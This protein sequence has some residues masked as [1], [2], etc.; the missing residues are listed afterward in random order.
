MFTIP[1]ELHEH[2]V[3][4]PVRA[5]GRDLWFLLD[6]GAG[7][8]L[9]DPA[10]AREAGHPLGPPFHARGAGDGRIEGAMLLSTLPLHPGGFEALRLDARA[11]LP[12]ADLTAAE[13]RRA[14]G[15]LGAD[16][17]TRHVVAIDYAA[18]RLHLHHP[19]EFAYTGPG[20]IVPM[21]LRLNH[22]HVR[23]TVALESGREVPADFV[24]DVG[25][26]LG[27]SLTRRFALEHGFDAAARQGAALRDG[28][29]IGG[30]VTARLTRIASVGIGA[31][32]WH[33]PMV[34]I[35]GEGAGVMSTGEFFD[36]NLGG[37]MLKEFTL[38]LDYARRYVI[39]EPRAAP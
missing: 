31:M 37:E 13:G 16:F 15:I 8:T 1:I 36:A 20:E 34:A 23:G 27:I 2:H 9:V 3:Y 28:R 4:V 25:S 21:E 26:R 14:D 5:G 17:L 30:G 22:P 24:V 6:T 10:A 32:T 35:F 7:L 19:A 12:I 38:F 11:V 39:F 33:E 29:G 18:R